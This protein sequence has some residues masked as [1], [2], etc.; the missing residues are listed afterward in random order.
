M[1]KHTVTR[2][3]AQRPDDPPVGPRSKSE[4]RDPYRLLLFRHQRLTER[5][6]EV[7][8][9]RE[10]VAQEIRAHCEQAMGLAA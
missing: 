4:R 6:Q 8:A 3:A 7:A 1:P 10:L 9:E 2:N 5:I